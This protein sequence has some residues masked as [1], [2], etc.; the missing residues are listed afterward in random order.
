MEQLQKGGIK[1]VAMKSHTHTGDAWKNGFSAAL[2]WIC[3]GGPNPADPEDVKSFKEKVIDAIHDTI[4]D[5]FGYDPS[6]IYVNSREHTTVMLRVFAWEVYQMLTGDSQENTMS[7]FGSVRKRATFA[8]M[9]RNIIRSL[10]YTP[11][12]KRDFERFLLGVQTRLDKATRDSRT[13]YVDLGLPSGTLWADRNLI[14]FH[15]ATLLDS[16]LVSLNLPVRKDFEE[17]MSECDSVWNETFG[18]ITFTGKNG[19]SV[20]FP[21]DG[22]KLRGANF[23]NGVFGQYILDKVEEK[24]DIFKFYHTNVTVMGF[25]NTNLESVAVSVRPV[26][27]LS[28]D[29]AIRLQ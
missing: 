22:F 21:A 7:A 12:Y 10:D 14:G 6:I 8:S 28:Y 17:L 23:K 20:F 9:K 24:D 29:K 13:E 26:L 3:T 11:S 25:D 16:S 15:G 1:R 27:R 2:H 19:K 4:R 5:D 18:G